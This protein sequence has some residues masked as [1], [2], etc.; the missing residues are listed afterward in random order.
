MQEVKEVTP[1]QQQD[2]TTTA[3]EKNVNRL[4]SYIGNE[5]GYKAITDLLEI[6]Y[7]KGGTSKEKQLS[8]I[9][10]YYQIEKVKSKY[11][12]VSKHDIPLQPTDNRQSIYYDDLS[13]L[14]LYALHNN[15]T[16]DCWSISKALYITTMTNKN[17]NEG[18]KDL[19]LTSKALEV[20]RSYLYDFYNITYTR[21][22]RIFESSLNKMQS[23]KLLQYNTILMTCKHDIQIVLNALGEPRVNSDGTI[24]YNVKEVF[25]EATQ[26]EREL[27]LYA[28]NKALNECNCKDIQ[29]VMLGRKYEY[30]KSIVNKIIRAEANIQYYYKAYD[31]VKYNT[32]IASAIETI[33]RNNSSRHINKLKV[34]SIINSKSKA[35]NRIAEDKE[36]LIKYL[37]DNT[38]HVK[39]E[40]LIDNIKED[41]EEELSFLE[42]ID[43]EL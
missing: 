20:D 1:Q 27:I 6:K 3:I 7:Y 14:I 18:R 9:Q 10:L 25:A 36:I 31:I 8:T 15:K 38:C 29:Q 30:Y 23:K 35:L 2:D 34:D 39:L 28:E 37:L 33:E 40:T 32:G 43:R 12:I 19:Y 26:Q 4:D 22:K 21:L 42:M 41:A 11:L 24:Q 17:Y 16:H 5:I 13:T